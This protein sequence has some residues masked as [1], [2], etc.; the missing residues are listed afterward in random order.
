MSLIGFYSCIKRSIPFLVTDWQ[1]ATTKDSRLRKECK[2][3]ALCKISSV[4]ASH[5]DKYE[6]KGDDKSAKMFSDEIVTLFRIVNFLRLCN[7]I[8]L[9]SLVAVDWLVVQL[10]CQRFK[11]SSFGQNLI[12]AEIST[13]MP[14]NSRLLR[15]C[16]NFLNKETT[17]GNVSSLSIRIFFW[18]TITDRHATFVME[19]V[20]SLSSDSKLKRSSSS[21]LSLS[22][23]SKITCVTL[24]QSRKN[25]GGRLVCLTQ[26]SLKI[27][28]FDNEYF[29]RVLSFAV[30]TISAKHSRRHLCFKILS[31]GKL[32]SA[33][34]IPFVVILLHPRR[35][36]KRM[37]LQFPSTHNL[38]IPRSVTLKSL[39]GDNESS[40]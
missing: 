20:W 6:S 33:S 5:M 32:S 11:D 36:N 28:I 26:K 15:Q 29:G 30:W 39:P 1:R 31:W 17:L 27:F 37:D 4:R 14:E 25:F 35:S 9:F 18:L 13:K 40:L 10:V 12:M 19:I 3:I 7:I 8:G 34:W 16:P 24:G 38:R 2:L 23:I 21:N 22:H